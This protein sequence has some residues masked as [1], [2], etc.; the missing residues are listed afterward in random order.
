MTSGSL[1]LFVTA[2]FT[3]LNPIGNTALFVGMVA[4][5]RAEERR[6]IA[7]TATAAVAVILVGTV[8]MG[9]VTLALFGVS[10]PTLQV[11][12]GLI[13]AS[14]G[15]SM[16]HSRQSAIHHP[17][18]G[19]RI[20][21]TGA[22]SIAVVP[23]AMP[24]VAGPGAIATIIVHTHRSPGVEAG[25]EMSLACIV[26]SV[27]VGACF[28]AGDPIT[29]LLG[30]TGINIITKFMGLILLSVAMGMLAGGVKELLPG[31]AL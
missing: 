6:R 31:L 7:L 18:D 12:G 13:I 20:A 10:V 9:E 22:E 30:E 25:V 26:L 11:A 23:L 8:W 2:M 3:I 14:I 27:V 17:G 4:D 16:L 28:L 29:R 24:I 5:R 15:F 19:E 21:V 1:L